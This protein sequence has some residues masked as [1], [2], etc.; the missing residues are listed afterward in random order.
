MQEY[1]LLTTN[2]IGGS[3][4]IDAFNIEFLK[5]DFKTSES[6][7]NAWCIWKSLLHGHRVNPV[8]STI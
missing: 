6:G 5:K 1:S 7:K 4:R 8:Q 3:Y 2:K